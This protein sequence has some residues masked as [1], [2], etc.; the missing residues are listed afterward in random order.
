MI[1]PKRIIDRSAK[2]APLLAIDI[3][4]N[5]KQ[6][7]LDCCRE[8]SVG[9]V[10]PCLKEG[11]RPR[12]A[13]IFERWMAGPGKLAWSLIRAAK[14]K[15]ETYYRYASG[16]GQKKPSLQRWRNCY[17]DLQQYIPA[18][19]ET[20]C[21]KGKGQPLLCDETAAI[22]LDAC[23]QYLDDHPMTELARLGYAIQSATYMSHYAGATVLAR[24]CQTGTMPMEYLRALQLPAATYDQW[25]A[26]H[27]I[28]PVKMFGRWSSYPELTTMRELQ[29]YL[30]GIEKPKKAPKRA[31]AP[32]E[33]QKKVIEAK[34][35]TTT[36]YS[37]F[38]QDTDRA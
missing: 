16:I 34:D 5:M 19:Y 8:E 2:V 23:K 26:Q 37:F 36:K 31:K 17:P 15:R 24:V 12:I 21:Q 20:M 30:A 11:I 18:G 6:A 4:D 9:T 27:P 38:D 28:E 32:R 29:D 3:P 1:L 25:L 7:V 35:E 14:A 13:D 33:T 22:F 10:F